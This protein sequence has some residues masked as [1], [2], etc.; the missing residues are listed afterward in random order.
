MKLQSDFFNFT[1]GL[2]CSLGS[3]YSVDYKIGPGAPKFLIWWRE[4]VVLSLAVISIAWKYRK[5]I[6]KAKKKGKKHLL[7]R[8]KYVVNK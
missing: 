4:L 8:G 1:V 6:K 7:R 5:P 3:L 2:I